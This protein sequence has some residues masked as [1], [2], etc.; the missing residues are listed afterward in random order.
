MNEPLAEL[1]TVLIPAYNAEATI[2]E[3]LLSVRR[4]THADLEIIVVDDGSNDRTCEIVGEHAAQDTRIRLLSQTNAG[5]A[6][7]RNKALSRAT[8]KFI[9]PIDADDLWHPN[10]IACQLQLI[11]ERGPAVSLVYTWYACIDS[12]SRVRQVIRSA[13]EGR[14]LS[15]LCAGNF[16]GHAS[17]PLMPT[18]SVIQAGGYDPSLRTRAAQGCEDWQLYLKLAEAGEFAVVKAP[19][20][21]YR[22]VGRGMSGDI[23]QMLRSHSLIR[24]DMQRAHPEYVEELREG[25]YKICDY[26]LKQAL[27]AK[28]YSVVSNE[29][30]RL[31]RSDPR[32]G[33]YLLY[34]FS[35][36]TRPDKLSR[37]LRRSFLSDESKARFER[38]YPNFMPAYDYDDCHLQDG[39]GVT[40]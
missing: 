38:A 37:I 7:A 36:R 30:W 33:C 9:A 23:A 2:E 3:T 31:S 17:S 16:I 24:A 15:A 18:E 1:V 26:Y 25:Y 21:G 39:A 20:T 13:H 12:R 27:K 29:F 8:G 34:C 35:L 28:R 40:N 22:Q 32:L 5:V 10:K 19:L 6:Q 14:V 4:Q 11:R